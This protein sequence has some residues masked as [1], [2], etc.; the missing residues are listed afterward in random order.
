MYVSYLKGQGLSF[1]QDLDKA[2]A[3][4]LQLSP[5]DGVAIEALFSELRKMQKIVIPVGR[6]PEQLGVLMVYRFFENL[7]LSLLC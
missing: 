5:K 4:W 6:P 2:K 7:F 3:E 1:Y